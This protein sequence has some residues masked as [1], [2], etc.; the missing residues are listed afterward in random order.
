MSTKFELSIELGND[1]MQNGNDIANALID[2]QDRLRM[3]ICTAYI[4]DDNGNTVG[5]WS[6]T[7][8]SVSSEMPA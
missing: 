2:V 5:E 1:A 4:K 7:L 8:A 6:M 3:G